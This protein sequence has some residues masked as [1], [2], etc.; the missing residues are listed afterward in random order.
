MYAYISM[1]ILSGERGSSST[2]S[3]SCPNMLYIYIYIGVGIHML[4]VLI[5]AGSLTLLP[6]MI[7]NDCTP[8]KKETTADSAA[9]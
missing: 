6:D 3:S 4:H 8:P 7:S 1:H 5:A 9:G 2:R